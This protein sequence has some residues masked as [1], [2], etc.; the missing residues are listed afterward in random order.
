[1]A[2]PGKWAVIGLGGAWAMI[3]AL[4]QL[5]PRPSEAPHSGGTLPAC[6]PYDNCVSSQSFSPESAITPL[7]FTGEPEPAQARLRRLIEALPGSNIVTDTPGYLSAV[8]RSRVF[9]FPDDLDC[10]IEPAGVIHIRS[11]ARLGRKDL[12]INRQRVEALRTQWQAA[13]EV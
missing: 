9:G 4:A 5:A 12:N 1:M 11:A 6:G 10:L 7:T 13:R 8:I 3:R 2:N